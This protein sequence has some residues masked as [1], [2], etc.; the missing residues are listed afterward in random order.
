GFRVFLFN[1]PHRFSAAYKVSEL[2]HGFPPPCSEPLAS[3]AADKRRMAL[4]PYNRPW[5]RRL[6]RGNP[7]RYCGTRSIR[8]CPLSCLCRGA[9]ETPARSP[10]SPPDSADEDCPPAPADTRREKLRL[11]RR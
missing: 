1:V 11:D 2:K 5:R 8:T 6:G 10:R 9:A 7:C 4:R 3:F